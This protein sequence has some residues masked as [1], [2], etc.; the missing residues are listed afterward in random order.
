MNDKNYFEEVIGQERAKRELSFYLKNHLKSGNPVPNFL[1]AGSKGDGK[2]F[3][4]RK[5][6]KNLPDLQNPDKKNKAFY[7]FNGG[8]IGNPTILMED[9]LSK[10]Q[11][12]YATVFVDEADALPSKVQAILLSILEPTKSNRTSV[13]FNDVTYEFDFRK[14]TFIF[15]TTETIFHSLEDRLKVVSLEPYSEEDL[16]KIMETVFEG[17]IDFEDDKLLPDLAHYVRRNARAATFVAKNVMSFGTPIFTREQFS[18][19]KTQLNMFPRGVNFT[20]VRALRILLEDHE[21]SLGH[22]A[23][24]LAQPSETT[25]K[26]IEPYLIALG[27]MIIEG[28][29][30]LTPE[31]RLYLKNI[32]DGHLERPVANDLVES[33]F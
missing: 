29:R 6:A 1:F 12:Q 30:K 10:V 7:S 19:L 14:I 8:Q 32:D 28:K 3:L 4:A 18:I 2:S 33:L 13:T 17:S 20:E 21:C 31:G 22:L 27:L 23:S 26:T 16:G 11:D 5:F 25:R 24:K 15:A 9:I